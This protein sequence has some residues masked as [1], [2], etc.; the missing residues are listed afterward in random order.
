MTYLDAM[1]IDNVENEIPLNLGSDSTVIA[2][3]LGI[4]ENTFNAN[5]IAIYPNP[6]KDM[7]TVDAKGIK[8]SKLQLIN[9]IGQTVWEESNVSG[10]K[11]VSTREFPAGI[12]ILQGV[13][14]NGTF[15]KKIIIEK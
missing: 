3:Y 14:Q 6:A 2:Q 1:I 15:S 11:Q 5:S 9:T 7:F 13:S 4:N 10:K 8:I 12:Y